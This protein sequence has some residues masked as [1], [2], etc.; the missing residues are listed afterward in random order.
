MK[1]P[2]SIAGPA[3]PDG[4]LSASR[5][6]GDDGRQDLASSRPH[7]GAC[8]QDKD[9]ASFTRHH[10]RHV[11]VQDSFGYE[12]R[13]DVVPMASCRVA[14]GKVGDTLQPQ[15]ILY[16]GWLDA[17]T[18]GGVARVGLAMTPDEADQLADQ[19]SS[20]L[21]RWAARARKKHWE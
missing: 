6:V 8:C 4:S 5:R 17:G 18:D 11:L 7:G 19:L 9:A 10:E 21:R 13:A 12:D 1:G 20:E 14:E 16:V 15:V 3:C 2:S